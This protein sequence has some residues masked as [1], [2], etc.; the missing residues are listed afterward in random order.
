[1]I[2]LKKI[3]IYITGYRVDWGPP[4]QAPAPAP[5]LLYRVYPAPVPDPDFPSF[6]HPRPDQV[7]QI[8]HRIRVNYHP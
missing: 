2:Y 3:T 5:I 4:Y 7:N 1:M 8:P 6:P